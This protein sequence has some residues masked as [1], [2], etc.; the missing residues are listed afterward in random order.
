MDGA[1]KWI[2]YDA[3]AQ[4]TQAMADNAVY[5]SLVVPA[6]FSA[7][8]AAAQTGGGEANPAVLTINQGKNPMA[9]IQLTTAFSALTASGLPLTQQVFRPVPA[10]LGFVAMLLPMITTLMVFIASMVG[11]LAISASFPLGAHRRWRTLTTQAAAAI[12]GA[13]LAGLGATTILNGLAGAGLGVLDGTLF[14]GLAAL[15]LMAIAIGSIN[16]FGRRGLAIPALIFVLSIATATLAYEFLPGFW[17]ACVYP[18]SP[19]R[20]LGDGTRALLFQGADWW[21]AATPGLLTCAII[22]LALMLSARFRPT[23]PHAHNPKAA[24]AALPRPEPDGFPTLPAL[25]PGHVITPATIR[26]HQDD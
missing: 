23:K 5:A 1:V 6:D 2:T 4:V 16:W 22:G 20:L 3:E 24:A 8:S 7:T 9:A 10:S 25:T 15:A 11:A 12:I 19:I 18:W 13:G 21:N 26:E 17:Q 14:V